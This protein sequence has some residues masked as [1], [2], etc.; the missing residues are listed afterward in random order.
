MVP[1]LPG[2]PLP[3]FGRADDPRTLRFDLLCDIANQ[4]GEARFTSQYVRA[5]YTPSERYVLDLPGT[6]RYRLEADTS[7]FTN[8]ALA[9]DWLFTGLGGAVESAVMSGMQ[10]ARG[11]CG[12]PATVPGEV[13][14]PWPRPRTLKRLV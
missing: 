4:T 9:G 13:P 14:S 8:L 11:L 5:N 3:R 1:E 7:G 2:A 12:L 6:A 10:A